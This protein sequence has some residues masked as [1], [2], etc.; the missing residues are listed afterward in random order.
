MRSYLTRSERAS[1]LRWVEA[2]QRL[3]ISRAALLGHIA[4]LEGSIAMHHDDGNLAGL[5]DDAIAILAEYPH[6]GRDEFMVVLLAVQ[7]LAGPANGRHVADWAARQR[8]TLHRREHIRAIRAARKRESD[9]NPAVSDS[10]CYV[11]DTTL[12]RNR[13]VTHYVIA[14]K[15]VA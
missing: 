2:A 14:V 10:A 1:D 12:L 11:T 3:G 13:Y 8:E 6:K 7:Y 15:Y 4:I 5:S 9:A